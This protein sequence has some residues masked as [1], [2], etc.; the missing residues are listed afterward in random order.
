M[1]REI[2]LIRDWPSFITWQ[3]G[4]EAEGERSKDFPD[5]PPPPVQYSD[6]PHPLAGSQFS[7]SS[8]RSVSPENHASPPESFSPP[9]KYDQSLI[10][11][12]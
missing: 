11:E 1:W 8:L 6:E 4:G 10:A 9:D 7:I 2:I 3:G 12:S 5:L